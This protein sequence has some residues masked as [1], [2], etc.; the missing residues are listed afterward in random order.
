LP[1]AARVLWPT[2]ADLTIYNNGATERRK[3]EFENPSALSVQEQHF[4]GR[5]AASL[6]TNK[7]SWSVVKQLNKHLLSLR[8]LSWTN[9]FAA[10]MAAS[11][12]PQKQDSW[13]VVITGHALLRAVAPER[14]CMANNGLS[15]Y[16]QRRKL[17]SG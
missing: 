17:E 4:A 1:S 7:H 11:S 8:L 16:K 6:S 9:L 2:S 14:L 12:F 13:S 5:A 3:R 15:F 10:I